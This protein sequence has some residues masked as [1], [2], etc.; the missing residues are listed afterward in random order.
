MKSRKRLLVLVANAVLA[1]ARTALA[2]DLANTGPPKAHGAPPVY[3]WNGLYFGGH[4]GFGRGSSSAVLGSQTFGDNRFGGLIGG[5]Q[6]GYNYVLPSHVLLGLEA[7]VSFQNTLESNS[8]ISSLSSGPNS[9]VEKMDFLTT[10][11]GRVG[12]VSGPCNLEQ[13]VTDSF[14]LFGRWSWNDGKTEIMSFTDIDASLSGGVS[15]KGTSWGRSDDTIGIA[16]AF[17]AL[18]ADHRDFT[19]AGGLGILIGDG[20]LNCRPEQILEIYYAYAITKTSA[21]TFDYQFIVN[22]AYNADRGPLSIFS[23]RIH[24]EF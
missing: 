24:A 16:G 18:S 17:N 3:D 9:V 15:I 14:G 6:A 2:A 10:A 11:R 20:R 21:L 1:G 23:G 13:S 22:P 12:Y 19:A 7:D 8:V 4:V 5:A